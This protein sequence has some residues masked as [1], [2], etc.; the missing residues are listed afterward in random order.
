MRVGLVAAGGFDRS[1]CDRVIPALLWLVER[2]ARRHDV[3]VFV[4]RHY[5]EPCTYQLAGA[6]IHDLGRVTA[7]RGLSTAV[8]ARRL[9]R[10]LRRA[11]P[12]DVLHGYWAAPAG[13]AAGLAGRWLDI[14]ALVSFDSGELVSLPDCDYGLQ[15]SARERAS[16]RLTARLAERLHVCSAHM[17]RLARAAGLEAECVPLGVDTQLFQPPARLPV[18]P[19]WRLVHVAS[20]RPVKDQQTLL[21][22]MALLLARRADDIHLDIVGEDTLDGAL[23]AQC[24][25]L[26]LTR[27]VTF[28]GFQRISRLPAF[29]DRAHLHVLTS[30]HEAAGVVVLEAAACGVP[31]VG[32]CTGY[33]ADWAPDAACAVPPGD[34]GELADAIDSLL[35]DPA[36][37]AALAAEAERRAR[38]MSADR[39]AMGI[40]GLYAGV[41]QHRR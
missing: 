25:V 28:H 15:R 40:E 30:R 6:T 17:L 36:R 19:P 31:T 13:L 41:L 12:F 7:P 33:V 34:P 1:G 24:A 21:R 32:S 22:A 11:G 20:L 10:A 35:D 29:Y 5:A 4:L 39:T 9:V 2:L 27:H 38:A 3:H 37:R 23:Q 14:P 16:V 8:H 18:G 26:G